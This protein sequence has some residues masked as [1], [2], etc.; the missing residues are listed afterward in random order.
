[1]KKKNKILL[2]I[3]YFLNTLNNFFAELPQAGFGSNCDFKKT[4]KYLENWKTT[5]HRVNVNNK[6]PFLFAKNYVNFTIVALPMKFNQQYLSQD[7]P[8]DTCRVLNVFYCNDFFESCKTTNVTIKGT[9]IGEACVNVVK[10]I[11]YIIYHVGNDGIKNINVYIQLTN[12]TGN[13]KQEFQIFYKW[14]ESNDNNTFER[15]GN[16]GYIEGKPIFVGTMITN[17]IEEAIVKN[18]IFNKSNPYFTLPM[19]NEIGYCDD[20]NRYTIKFLEDVK[21]KCRVAV[22]T[23]NFSTTTCIKLQNRTFETL[24]NFM[25][26]K[27]F[28]KINLN[29][30]YVSKSGNVTN[31]ETEDWAKMFFEKIPQ[32]VITAQTTNNELRC[33]GLVNS[34]AFDVVHSLI[35]KPGTNNNYNIL[36]IGV[37]FSQDVD[38]KWT[39]CF[40]KNCTDELIL[41]LISYVSF[42]DV[43][44]PTRYHIAGGPNLDISLPY[45]FFY[46]FVSQSKGSTFLLSK[47]I[48]CVFFIYIITIYT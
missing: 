40:L 19:A 21:L 4:V 10:K 34:V 6:N 8:T 46:P 39:K 17:K 43:S 45:D 12:V 26:S 28:D 7:C 37:T 3:F 35:S 32:N 20:I 13:F 16:P 29:K 30:Q 33:S 15:S 27:D 47:E 36:G 48:V 38:L 41:D 31:N 18:V 2:P 42:H 14:Y 11:R 25:S 22:E 1:M 44:K 23:S 24:I 9:C 5:C